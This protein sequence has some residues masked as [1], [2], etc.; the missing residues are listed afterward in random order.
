MRWLAPSRARAGRRASRPPSP[1]SPAPLLDLPAHGLGQ[2]PELVR[3]DRA[4]LDERYRHDPGHRGL[5][6][7]AALVCEL[8]DALEQGV[9]LPRRPRQPSARRRCAYCRFRAR[10]GSP[11]YGGDEV[12]HLSGELAPLPA[13]IRSAV[14]LSASAKFSTYAQSSGAGRS[15]ATRSSNVRTSPPCRT[16][17]RRRQKVV[18]AR[19]DVQSERR[20]PDRPWLTQRALQGIELGGRAEGQRTRVPPPQAR[21]RKRPRPSRATHAVHTTRGT[22]RSRIST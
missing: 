5:R 16:P 22:S 12:V 6:R 14:A 18:T 7:E 21:R 2:A 9:S 13:G 3:L 17:A 11:R 20:A 1:G 8:P 4:A 15:S 19:I 10:P